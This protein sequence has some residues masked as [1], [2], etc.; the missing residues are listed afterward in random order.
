VRAPARIVA[1]LAGCAVV[2]ASLQ[3]PEASQPSRAS[4]S[5]Q[6][7]GPASGDLEVLQLRP[8]FF[9]IIC[10]RVTAVTCSPRSARSS[11]FSARLE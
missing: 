2:A 6:S 11:R 4:S 3:N 5:L 8:N 9:M 7:A 1:V 10:A